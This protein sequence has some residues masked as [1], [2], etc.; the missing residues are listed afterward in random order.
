MKKFTLTFALIAFACATILSGQSLQ[1][2]Y[3]DSLIMGNAYNDGDIEGISIVENTS[4]DTLEVRFKRIDGNYNALTDSNA[5]CWG[6]CFTT[7]ISVSPISFTRTIEPG[8]T[9]T[10]ITHV[11]PDQDGIGRTGSITYVYFVKDAPNDSVA[12][13][14]RYEVTPDLSTQERAEENRSKLEIFP[15]P[16]NQ[17]AA[18]L[19]YELANTVTEGS[20]EMLNLVGEVVLR[21]SLENK[22]GKLRLDLNNFAPG[23]YYYRL[24][25]EGKSLSTRKLIIR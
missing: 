19:D 2:T 18:Q 24:K 15:N 5:I 6:L 1:V 3:I 22:K 14:V 20:F 7:N 11:Y 10:A 12:Y 9:D 21:R 23:V 25:Q 8:G 17:G 16:V 4:S 13:S